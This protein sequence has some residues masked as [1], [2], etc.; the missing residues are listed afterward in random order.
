MKLPRLPEL[1]PRERLLAVSSGVALLAV[2][3]DFL[4]LNPWLRHAQTVRDEIH[5]MEAEL[6]HDA[7]L[8]S[9]RDRV[10]KQLAVYQPYLRSPLP[11]ELQ[12][13]GLLKE[14]QGL[15]DESQLRVEI[16]PL[17][18]E[19]TELTIRYSLD[20]QFDCTLE[21][22][23]DFVIKVEASPSLFQVARAGLTV[24]EEMP[25]RLKATLRLT[26]TSLRGPARGAT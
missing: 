20:V 15:A 4:V 1:K 21:E 9:R 22:W 6:R 14:I 5:R 12:M 24:Q 17:P 23:V 2:A 7:R 25:D 10:M 18:A 19:P 3:L 26:S 11:D 13:A 8:L 16:K